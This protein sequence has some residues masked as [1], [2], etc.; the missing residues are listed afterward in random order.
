MSSLRS[1][2]SARIWTSTLERY[3]PA[4]LR[5]GYSEWNAE[6][7]DAIYVA[8]SRKLSGNAAEI[9]GTCLLISD[10]RLTPF[11][12]RL[13]VSDGA[14]TSYCLKLGE[15]GEGR[16]GISGPQFSSRA[17]TALLVNLAGRLD[18]IQWVYAIES[19]DE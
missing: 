12:V 19:G 2:R 16:L 8:A 6:S 11:F 5:G 3:L 7:L 9:F 17:A 15:S 10:Q 14:V 1:C 4:L 18:Q 13:A